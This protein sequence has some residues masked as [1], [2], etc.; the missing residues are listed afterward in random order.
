MRHRVARKTIGTQLCR[1]F[2]YHGD[3]P[4]G[5]HPAA[6]YAN[7][8]AEDA[9]KKEGGEQARIGCSA[10]FLYYQKVITIAGKSD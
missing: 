6:V 3:F 2:Q 9:G 5:Y 4:G 8:E 1:I 10:K 7:P